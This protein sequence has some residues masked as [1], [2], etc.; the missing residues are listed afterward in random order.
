[1]YLILKN[2]WVVWVAKSSYRAEQ[3][4]LKIKQKEPGA[5]VRI[6]QLPVE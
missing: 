5:I 1:M 3:I 4:K 6:K 2:G